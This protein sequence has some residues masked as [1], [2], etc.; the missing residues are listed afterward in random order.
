[1]FRLAVRGRWLIA[2][3]VEPVEDRPG[4]RAF[5]GACNVVPL[6]D[7]SAGVAELV[8][9]GSAGVNGGENGC[10]GLAE[11]VGDDP[12]HAEPGAGCAPLIAKVGRIPEGSYRGTED[13]LMGAA[14]QLLGLPS[15]QH[16]DEKARNPKPT[17]RCGGPGMV[18]D[19]QTLTRTLMT[20]P[21]MLSVGGS[22]CR[23]TSGQRNAS[24][25]PI[26]APVASIR[27]GPEDRLGLPALPPAGSLAEREL[28]PRSVH[29]LPCCPH[30]R[31]QSPSRRFSGAAS[32]RAAR[33]NMPDSTLRASRA[34]AWP[35]R[36]SMLRRNASTR[37]TVIS[38]TSSVHQA[39]G[40]NLT[41]AA[42]QSLGCFIG[43]KRV[44]ATPTS[45]EQRIAVAQQVHVIPDRDQAV[46]GTE[47]TE[48]SRPE[49][50][51][52]CRSTGPT[53]RE[54]GHPPPELQ[55]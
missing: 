37:P 48:R 11:R 31:L 38:P 52:P 40:L 6:G 51:R 19:H 14:D 43:F 27:Q 42:D 13:H 41:S 30:G 54:Y 10:D 17:A 50:Q 25:S 28:R 24:T 22:L 53:G 45:Q 44:P 3:G 1:M 49:R 36:G 47:T 35:W 32:C 46:V 16:I 15:A 5:V 18:L 20:V 4:V 33:A 8:G 29:V 12:L 2:V 9:C 55:C 39:Y 7:R 34:D 21:E 26:R 23:S